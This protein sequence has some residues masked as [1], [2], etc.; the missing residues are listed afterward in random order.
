MLTVFGARAVTELPTVP[1][2]CSLT[3][4]ELKEQLGRY[5]TVGGSAE[6]LVWNKSRRV[7]RVGAAVPDVL[8]ERL[9]EVE[10][11][12][13]PFFDLSWDP[14]SRRLGISVADRGHEPALDAIGYALGVPGPQP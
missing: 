10:R 7:L 9:I 14:R 3:A 2:S 11:A 6:V 8:V 1:P 4:P 13:C 5:K 12:C